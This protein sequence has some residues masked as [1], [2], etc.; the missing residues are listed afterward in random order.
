M[1]LTVLVQKFNLC[2]E[3]SLGLG[4]L[5]IAGS[6]G[7]EGPSL[8]SPTYREPDRKGANIFEQKL[9]PTRRSGRNG[10]RALP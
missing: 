1:Y 8:F 3:Y 6:V 4:E 5:E 10:L 7:P 2:S 9:T